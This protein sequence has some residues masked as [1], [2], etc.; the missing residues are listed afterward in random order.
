MGNP[1]GSNVLRECA[2]EKEKFWY[3]NKFIA[4][5]IRDC[6][7]NES[8]IENTNVNGNTYYDFTVLKPINSTGHWKMQSIVE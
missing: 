6:A 7:N 1:R 5:F 2:W 4:S 3:K 8:K